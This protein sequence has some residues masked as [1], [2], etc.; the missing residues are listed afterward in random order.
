MSDKIKIGDVVRLN[1]SPE[2]PRLTVVRDDLTGNPEWVRCYWFVEGLLQ[3]GDFPISALQRI[4][5][6]NDDAS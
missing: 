4:A 5:R 1:S 2:G 6:S 3:M